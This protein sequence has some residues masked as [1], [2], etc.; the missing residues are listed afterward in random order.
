MLRPIKWFHRATMLSYGVMLGDGRLTARERSLCVRL[1]GKKSE[2]EIAKSLGLTLPTTRG[3]IQA[4]Y[5]K[6]GVQGRT[7]LMAL[8]LGTGR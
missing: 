3:Y 5:K 6:F 7:G 2:K 8:W 4:L 1:L